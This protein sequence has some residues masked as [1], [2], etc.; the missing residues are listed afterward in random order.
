MDAFTK[1]RILLLI[2]QIEFDPTSDGRRMFPNDTSD[3]CRTEPV[4]ANR[5]RRQFDPTLNQTW[6]AKTRAENS[7]RTHQ[8]MH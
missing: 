1:G 3:V 5:T 6:R 4:A 8:P 2:E 7:A